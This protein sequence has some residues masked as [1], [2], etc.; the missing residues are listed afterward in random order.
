MVLLSVC[1]VLIDNDVPIFLFLLGT[2][3]CGDGNKADKRDDLGH[4]KE[5][6]ACCREHDHC[7]DH[8]RAGKSKYGL[9]NTGLFTR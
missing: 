8:I 5:P 2:L 4:F 7:F 3:W 6:D 9:V 1:P